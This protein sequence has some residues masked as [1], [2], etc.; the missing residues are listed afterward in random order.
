VQSAECPSASPVGEAD[1]AGRMQ[2]AEQRTRLRPPR[3]RAD[4]AEAG[5]ETGARKP[6]RRT[7]ANVQHS[8]LNPGAPGLRGTALRGAKFQVNGGRQVANVQHSTLN[9]G[10]PGLRGTTRRGAKFQVN[11][12]R[13]KAH[14]GNNER[15]TFNAQRSTFRGMA[16]RGDTS[17]DAQ[18]TRRRRRGRD[19]QWTVRRGCVGGCRCC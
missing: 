1:E 7:T 10:A 12:G 15:P 3:R 9:P 13:R 17:R 5:P 18:Y 19:R 2:N 8:T 4:F 11:G 16:R 6:E 14:G